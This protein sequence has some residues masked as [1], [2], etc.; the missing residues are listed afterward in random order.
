MFKLAACMDFPPLDI[1]ERIQRSV[2]SSLYA[3]IQKFTEK[4]K[5]KLKPVK[6]LSSMTP[7]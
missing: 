7:R 1:K 4:K 5:T 3:F 6:N 2:N